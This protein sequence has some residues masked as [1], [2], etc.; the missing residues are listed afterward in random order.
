MCSSDLHTLDIA[1]VGGRVETGRNGE[2]VEAGPGGVYRAGHDGVSGPAGRLATVTGQ[3]VGLSVLGDDLYWFDRDPFAKD[4]A[5][6]TADLRAVATA[7]GEVRTL[8]ARVRIPDEPSLGL[9]GDRVLWITRDHA[10]VA[11][12]RAGGA[13]EVVRPAEHPISRLRVTGDTLW[14]WSGA[15]IVTRPLAGGPEALVVPSFA[16]VEDFVVTDRWIVGAQGSGL[17]RVIAVER[18]AITTRPSPRAGPPP[19]VGE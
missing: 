19:A 6:G 15:G 1:V 17:D 3:P 2:E 5:W 13:V 16:S 4:A 10:I 12:P 18:S 8:A 9:A 14:W 7:G 11:V